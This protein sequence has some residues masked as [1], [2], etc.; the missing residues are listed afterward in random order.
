M[1]LNNISGLLLLINRICRKSGSSSK[2]LMIRFNTMI[3]SVMGPNRGPN[4]YLLTFTNDGL[5]VR[6][7]STYSTINGATGAKPASHVNPS[8][9]VPRA[10]GKAMVRVEA[11]VTRL[12]A[13]HHSVLSLPA[14]AG[15]IV[16]R[17]YLC[18]YAAASHVYV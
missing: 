11:R 6:S 8:M 2:I 13:L 10:R 9:T 12:L 15:S 16:I 18:A 3:F 17:A 5:L 7:P 14:A 4:I 1:F